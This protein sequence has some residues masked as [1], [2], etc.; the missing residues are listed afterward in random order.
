[1]KY[2]AR[3]QDVLG[4]SRH[5]PVVRCLPLE[6]YRLSTFTNGRADLERREDRSTHDEE[7]RLGKISARTHSKREGK[8]GVRACRYIM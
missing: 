2:T 7:C 4:N 6:L 3:K 8:G 5:D 1:M